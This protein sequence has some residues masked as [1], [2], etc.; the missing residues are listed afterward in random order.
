MIDGH[1][2]VIEGIDGAGTSTQAAELKKRFS[3][4]GLPAHVTAEPSTGPMGSIIRQILSGRLIVRRYHGVSAP[5]WMTMSLLFAADRHDHLESEIQP[6][7]REGVNVICDRYMYSSVVYQSV[8]SED[9]Q[10]AQWI[11]EI[12]RYTTKP[13]LVLCL[14]VSLEEAMRRRR[15]RNQSVE[16]FDD[17]AFQQKLAV[18]YDNLTQMFPEVNIITIDA[19]RPVDEI[20]EECWSHVEKLRSTKA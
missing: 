20:T 9:D 18:A 8:S 2:I 14:R 3:E 7:L 13:D 10:T 4:F 16:I 6:N 5:N 19:D 1:F 15:E 11:R 12:N 17:P